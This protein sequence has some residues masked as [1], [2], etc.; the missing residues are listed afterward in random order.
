[1]IVK[2]KTIYYNNAVIKVYDIPIFLF[3]KIISPRSYC[4]R[5]S[6]FLPPHFNNSK[7]LGNGIS[8]TLFLGY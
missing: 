4:N 3:T 8:N 7:N 5:R 6:G 2:K 1:M